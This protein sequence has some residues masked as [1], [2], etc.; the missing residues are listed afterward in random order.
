M[1]P[2]MGAP[3]LVTKEA[4]VERA[5]LVDA[6]GSLCGLPAGEDAGRCGRTWCGYFDE[7][8]GRCGLLVWD[9]PSRLGPEAMRWFAAHR[10]TKGLVDAPDGDDLLLA[11]TCSF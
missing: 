8:R 9:L 10:T 5:R 11:R 6:L 3:A 7:G 1:V 4:L 2:L